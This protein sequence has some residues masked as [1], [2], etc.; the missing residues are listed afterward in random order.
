VRTLTPT[1]PPEH[2]PYV[3]EMQRALT[4]FGFPVQVDGVWGV[5]SGTAAYRAKVTLGYAKPDHTAGDLLLAYLTGRKKPTAAMVKRAKRQPPVGPTPSPAPA[6]PATHEETVRG[7]VVATWHLLVANASKVHYPPG[8]RRTTSN[9]HTI[10]SRDELRA[11]LASP[12]GLTADC[13]QTASMVA[14][15]AGAKCPDGEYAANWAA[16]GYTGTMLAGSE[17]ISV[18]QVKVGDFHV[19][20]PGTGHHVAQCLQRAG[21][22]FL[23]GSH[24]SDPPRLILDSVEASYQPAGGAWLRLPL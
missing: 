18:S 4:A 1:H 3:E 9:I 17:H 21:R 15:I 13:S 24:G 22:D 10:S 19:Y 7:A 23:M 12:G 5:Q 8:D 11:I 14:H 6:P 2:G 20:G 16:D